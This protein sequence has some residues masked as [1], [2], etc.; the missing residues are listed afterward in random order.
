MP[1]SLVKVSL[2]DEAQVIIAVSRKNSSLVNDYTQ[3]YDS[4]PACSSWSFAVFLM[5]RSLRK[6]C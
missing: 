2:V 6:E 3:D 1:K 5:F 4:V